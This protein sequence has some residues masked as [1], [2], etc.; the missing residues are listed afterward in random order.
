MT[1]TVTTPA[2]LWLLAIVPT[3]WFGRWVTRDEPGRELVRKLGRSH[4]LVSR[5]APP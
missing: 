2:A 4:R 3:V 1:I 5:S